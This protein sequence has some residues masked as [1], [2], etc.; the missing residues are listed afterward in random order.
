MIFY[1]RLFCLSSVPFIF[2][3]DKYWKS[4]LRYCLAKDLYQTDLHNE[5]DYPP[6]VLSDTHRCARE[7]AEIEEEQL[8]PDEEDMDISAGD[9]ESQDEE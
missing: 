5:R 1:P 6:P 2:W 8:V 7:D 4:I 3:Q 9:A